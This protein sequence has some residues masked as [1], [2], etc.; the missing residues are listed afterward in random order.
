MFCNWIALTF[1]LLLSGMIGKSWWEREAEGCWQSGLWWRM[2]QPRRRCPVVPFGEQKLLFCDEKAIFLL[3]GPSCYS[4]LCMS[5][6][7]GFE[8]QDGPVLASPKL[9]TADAPAPRKG[10]YSFSSVFTMCS[11]HPVIP[12]GVALGFHRNK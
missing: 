10:L 1:L 6:C 8:H 7:E 4:Q 12:C 2:E 9:H 11:F 5:Q 3:S